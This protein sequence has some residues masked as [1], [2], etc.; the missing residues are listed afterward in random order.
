MIMAGVRISVPRV[1]RMR[2][3]RGFAEQSVGKRAIIEKPVAEIGVLRPGPT[4]NREYV[5]VKAQGRSQAL[6]ESGAKQPIP[7]ADPG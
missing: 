7:R 6:A 2:L 1:M 4:C 3:A 5:C